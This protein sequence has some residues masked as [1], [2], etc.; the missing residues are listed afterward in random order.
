MSTRVRIVVAGAVVALLVVALIAAVWGSRKHK[1]A[2]GPPVTVASSTTAT[3]SVTRTTVR[4]PTSTAR[5]TP[6]TVTSLPT[7]SL[8]PPFS[9]AQLELALLQNGDLPVDSRRAIV[10]PNAWSGVC[11]SAAPAFAAPVSAAAVDFNGPLGLHVREDLADYGASAGGYLD[12]VRAKVACEM[13]ASDG[14]PGSPAITVVPI[15][16]AQVAGGIDTRNGAVGLAVKTVDARR[17]TSFYVWLRQ[18]D[19]VISVQDDALTANAVSAVQLAQL[20]LER[21]K[22]TLA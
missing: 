11:G 6:S 22:N 14:R 12:A 9:S 4:A 3:G 5:T 1:A 20:A 13:Y 10:A 15:P 7:I 8:P 16:P 18:G 17:R 2:A 21:V 19:V